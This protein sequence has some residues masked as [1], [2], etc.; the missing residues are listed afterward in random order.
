MG[1]G[2]VWCIVGGIIAVA[3]LAWVVVT[4]QHHGGYYVRPFDNGAP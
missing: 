4:L 1:L 3:V 2:H